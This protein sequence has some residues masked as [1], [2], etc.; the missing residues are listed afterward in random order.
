YKVRESKGRNRKHDYSRVT[1]EEKLTCRLVGFGINV[2]GLIFYV[3]D[4]FG[5]NVP[6]LIFSFIDHRHLRPPILLLGCKFTTDSQVYNSGLSHVSQ[7]ARMSWLTPPTDNLYK[8]MAIFGI[9][10]VVTG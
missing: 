7:E 2:L 3:I 4:D 6:V 8:F 10:L 9:V 1:L 5:I